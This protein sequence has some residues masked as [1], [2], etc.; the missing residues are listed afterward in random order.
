MPDNVQN[1]SEQNNTPVRAFPL[2]DSYMH[3]LI[4]DPQ[5]R[6]TF[7]AKLKKSNRLIAPL[8]KLGIL[9]LFGMSKTIMLL[10]TMGRKSKKMRDTPI[11]YFLIDDD[12]YLFSAWGKNANWYKN[13]IADP[14]HVTLQIGFRRFHVTPEFVEDPSQRQRIYEQL[15]LQNP[16]GA[17]TLLNW[18]EKTDRLENADFT[19]LIEKVVVV[20]FRPK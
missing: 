5:F 11:G 6:Q 19:V 10:S 1:N 13:M 14:Q 2:P 3:Q 9:P 16:Q 8:Y 20:R 7:N 17:K 4:Y 12:I 18:D 15:V